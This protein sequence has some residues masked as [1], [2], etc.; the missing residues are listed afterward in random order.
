MMEFLTQYAKYIGIGVVILLEIV[1]LIL[2]KKPVKLV[3]A[4]TAFISSVLPQAI[5]QCEAE[6]PAGH[7]AEKLEMVVQLV[8][9]Y[10][11]QSL[12]LTAFEAEK[13]RKVIITKT[14]DILS[15]P[16]KK[17]GEN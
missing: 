5:N 3:D 1:I 16:Q 12:G 15:T 9:T 2:K 13:Y 17:K 7:G 4:V 6:Y 11:M 14:E 8:I 10:L